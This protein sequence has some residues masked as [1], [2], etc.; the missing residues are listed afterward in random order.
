MGPEFIV[1]IVVGVFLV[2]V[3]ALSIALTVRM[4]RTYYYTVHSHEVAVKVGAGGYFL[5][6]DGTLEEQFSGQR[7]SR[8]TLRATV[9]GEE[10]KAHISVSSF[11][12]IQIQATHG[13]REVVLVRVE[14]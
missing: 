13:G 9:D 1:S 6:V 4:K 14:K 3:L 2:L 12:R 8:V 5:Y 11:S 10:F 7:M